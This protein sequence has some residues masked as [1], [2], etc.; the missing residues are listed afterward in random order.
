MTRIKFY[1]NP[2]SLPYYSKLVE[3]KG[4]L[5]RI[6]TIIDPG[7][8]RVFPYG[9]CSDSVRAVYLKT[10]L[11][12]IGG[13]FRRNKH[14]WNYDR[15][16]GLYIDLTLQQFGNFPEIAV[17]DASSGVLIPHEGLTE[18]QKMMELEDAVR[19]TR[20]VA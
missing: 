10:G 6:L 19:A 14:A 12:E 18:K 13:Y 3:L 11:E 8:F 4:V 5:G 17:I 7:F 9:C 2:Q 15:K 1:D 16:K 20:L